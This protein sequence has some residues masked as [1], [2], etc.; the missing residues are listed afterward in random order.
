MTSPEQRSFAEPVY[1]VSPDLDTNQ[2]ISAVLNEA[3]HLFDW[4][5]EGRWAEEKERLARCLVPH[6]RAHPKLTRSIL[7]L[8]DRV[9]AMVVYR[10]VAL[11]DRAAES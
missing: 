10:A 11:L 2:R 3:A 5:A 7:N 4:H 1:P 8:N 6:L 9:F